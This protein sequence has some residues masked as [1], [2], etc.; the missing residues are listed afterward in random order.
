MTDHFVHS[1][2]DFPSAVHRLVAMDATGNLVGADTDGFLRHFTVK[3]AIHLFHGWTLAEVRERAEVM[4]RDRKTECDWCL[5][6]FWD[7]E[8]VYQMD[9]VTGN[10]TACCRG[11]RVEP[12]VPAPCSHPTGLYQPESEKWDC[13]TC[14]AIFARMPDPFQPEGA[15]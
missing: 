10:E 2:D 13:S 3:Q 1:P 11:C 14:G 15:R 8:L 5:G 7:R 6:K 9:P 12:A 4:D